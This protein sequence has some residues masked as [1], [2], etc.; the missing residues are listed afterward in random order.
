MWKLKY[1]LP[2]SPTITTI[3]CDSLSWESCFAFNAG[4]PLDVHYPSHIPALHWCL[5]LALWLMSTHV[6]S[7]CLLHKK[8]DCV[9]MSSMLLFKSIAIGTMCNLYCLRLFWIAH[10]IVHEVWQMERSN[11][12]LCH[13]LH[14]HFSLAPHCAS[15]KSLEPLLLPSLAYVAPKSSAGLWPWQLV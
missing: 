7:T 3:R 2:I 1:L 13:P 14:T 5:P 9:G 15:D 6:G 8:T 10:V 11:A 4:N 12:A